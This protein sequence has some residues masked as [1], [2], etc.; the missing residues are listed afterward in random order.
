MTVHLNSRLAT[1]SGIDPQRVRIQVFMVS[2]PISASAGWLYAYQRAY[3]SADV[4]DT[5]FLILMLTAVV[6]VGRRMLLA[7]LAGVALILLQEKFLSFGAY[8]DE[9]VVAC[10][11]P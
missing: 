1:M 8:V 3:I 5:Y 7:P 11:A 9:D 6:L 4:L 10:T 2:A